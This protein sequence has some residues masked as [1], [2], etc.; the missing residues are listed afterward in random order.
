ME[1]ISGR[2][3]EMFLPSL[4]CL[5]CGSSAKAGGGREKC[6][7][8]VLT[9]LSLSLGGVGGAIGDFKRA[10]PQTFGISSF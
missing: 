8:S 3:G 6:S 9:E 5:G 10:V 7:C 1:W 4:G 2:K